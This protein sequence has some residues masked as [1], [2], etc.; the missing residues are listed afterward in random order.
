LDRLKAY[1]LAESGI[2]K[3]VHELKHD[4][5]FDNNGIGN[6]LRVK[7]AG[8]TYKASHNFQASIITATGEYNHVKRTIQIKYSAL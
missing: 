3:A 5:D 7:L 8:G 1:Y 2:A 4:K 6:I